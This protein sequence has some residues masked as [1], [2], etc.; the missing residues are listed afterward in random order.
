MGSIQNR[1]SSTIRN[2]EVSAEN[3]SASNSRIRDTDYAAAT[4]ENTRLSFKVPV[5][6]SLLKLMQMDKVLS[7]SLVNN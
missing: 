4:A 6:P 5:V 2:L 1:L 3:I 7:G